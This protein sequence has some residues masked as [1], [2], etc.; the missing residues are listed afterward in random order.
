M[1]K[2]R[3]GTGPGS[4][5]RRAR[6]IEPTAVAV[7]GWAHEAPCADGSRHPPV[8]TLATSGIKEESASCKQKPQEWGFCFSSE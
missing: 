2:S 1:P 8:G 3:A 5:E 4:R 6:D 7:N